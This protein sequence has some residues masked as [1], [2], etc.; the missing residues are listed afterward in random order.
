MANNPA[1]AAMGRRLRELLQ[2]SVWS[3]WMIPP[4]SCGLARLQVIPIESFHPRVPCSAAPHTGPSTL[5]LLRRTLCFSRQ[6]VSNTSTA[7]FALE[8]PKL[9][10]TNRGCSVIQ[11]VSFRRHCT[12][13]KQSKKLV[14]QK[15]EFSLDENYMEITMK[16]TSELHCRVLVAFFSYSLLKL[17][18]KI[19]H[20]MLIGCSCNTLSCCQEFKT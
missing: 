17:I 12:V 15:K 7:S 13:T 5:L 20:N 6:Q 16:N 14:F 8:T 10:K 2:I 9:L 4:S 3:A 18:H 19:C 1:L 11:T